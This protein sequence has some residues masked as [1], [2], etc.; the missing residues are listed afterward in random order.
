MIICNIV[1]Q[2]ELRVNYFHLYLQKSSLE[3]VYVETILQYSDLIRLNYV[4]VNHLNSSLFQSS[5]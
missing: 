1:A 2:I 3:A 4:R 5:K